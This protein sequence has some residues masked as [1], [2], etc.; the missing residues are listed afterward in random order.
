MVFAVATSP[1]LGDKKMIFGTVL[2]A[3]M[4]VRNLNKNGSMLT[5]FR[6]DVITKLLNNQ[7]YEVVI[8]SAIYLI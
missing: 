4:T 7:N 1:C 6:D 2:I 3:I 8:F 5:L